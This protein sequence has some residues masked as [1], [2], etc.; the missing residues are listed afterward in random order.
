MRSCGISNIIFDGLNEHIE[1][2]V[3]N[4]N[5]HRQFAHTI[6]NEL[7]EWNKYYQDLDLITRQLNRGYNP[8]IPCNNILFNF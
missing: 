7:N 3:L 6:R 5:I 1:D 2:L 4:Y 8:A